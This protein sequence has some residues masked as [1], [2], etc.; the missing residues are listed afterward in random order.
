MFLRQRP[1]A[2]NVEVELDVRLIQTA[3]G[4]VAHTYIAITEDRLQSAIKAGE[5][6]GKLLHHD[7]VVRE[8]NGPLRTDGTG[9]LHWKSAIAVRPDWK[10]SDLSLVAFVQD[11]RNGEF[12][13]PMHVPLC[14]GQ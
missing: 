14:A 7:F 10:R 8:L 4:G 9:R 12:L 3:A 6:Q 11:E 13:Q 5:N 1:A 2:S